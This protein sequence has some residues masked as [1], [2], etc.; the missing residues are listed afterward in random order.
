MANARPKQMNTDVPTGYDDSVP[1]LRDADMRSAQRMIP[2]DQFSE[3][4]AGYVI[5]LIEQWCDRNT[6][7]A[8]HEL[9]FVLEQGKWCT[10][11][12]EMVR[13][14]LEQLPN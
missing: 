1:A 3:Q 9:R 10:G 14:F 5:T 8:A 4:A 13:L 6:S 2:F 12:R 11:Y 7:Q